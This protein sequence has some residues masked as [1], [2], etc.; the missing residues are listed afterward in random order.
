M[1]PIHFGHTEIIS[2]AR[3][4]S[5]IGLSAYI[6]RTALADEFTGASFTFFHKI[7]DLVHREVML[8][9]GV[10]ERFKDAGILW[11]EATK[12][13]ITLDRKT[14]RSRFK[15]GA[16]VAKHTILALPKEVSD[17][18][19][20]ELAR[21]FVRDNFTRF[22]VAVELAIHK[23]DAD[24]PDNHHAHILQTTRIVSSKGFGNKARKLNPGFATNSK[25][26]RFV[27]DQDR[28]SDRW[29]EA[30]NVFFHELG[31]DLRVDPKRIVPGVHL[32]PSREDAS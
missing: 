11:N 3:G 9:E 1:S 6:S 30:Q 8:P 24:S 14:R 19:R 25:L 13:E 26:E 10:H 16:Q 23:P 5:A 21:R 31:L 2:A 17:A 27:S 18:E 15:R 32:G 12:K 7:N 22:G 4:S 29:A 20:L 28:I